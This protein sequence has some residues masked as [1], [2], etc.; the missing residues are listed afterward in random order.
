[1]SKN[2]SHLHCS[3]KEFKHRVEPFYKGVK[4]F[5]HEW[6]LKLPRTS[7]LPLVCEVGG[8]SYLVFLK[9]EVD[10]LAKGLDSTLSLPE[11]KF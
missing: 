4:A 8:Q 9:W 6:F 10:E 3:G 5:E 11:S 1:M 7:R 2:I